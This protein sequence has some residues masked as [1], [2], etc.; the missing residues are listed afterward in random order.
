M[1]RIQQWIRPRA[2][3]LEEAQREYMINIVILGLAITGFL[4]GLASLIIWLREGGPWIGVAS[5][6][7]VQPIYAIAYGLN[8]KGY[9]RAATSIVL[10]VLFLIMLGGGLS[11]GIGHSTMVG[12]AMII[13]IAGLLLGARPAL[14]LTLL[15]GGSYA[16]VGWLQISGRLAT[17]F[18]PEV[19]LWAD[20]AAITT[21]LAAVVVVIWLAGQQLRQA[22]HAEQRL[23]AELRHMVSTLEQ[24]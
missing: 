20:V 16:L 2:S 11:V 8:R 15:C 3:D 1:M 12:Y 24:Q 4:F 7:G 18:P 9:S 13:A 6:F 23:S 19:T 10:T 5:G 21:G 22:L 17:A 14:F